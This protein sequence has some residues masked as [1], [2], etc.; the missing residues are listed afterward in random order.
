MEKISALDRVN[1]WA[2]RSVTLKLMSIGILVLILLIPTSMLTSL[3]FERETVR[4][5]AIEE[6]SSKW[7]S[8]QTIGG[9]VLTVPYQVLTKDNQGKTETEIRFAHFLPEHLQFTGTVLP[10]KRYRGIYVVVLYTAKIH[11]TGSFV[12]PDI[13]ALSIPE[14]NYL[15]KESSVSIGI[16]D[17]KGINDTIN[18][19]M[20]DTTY[21]FN[22]GLPSSE[23]LASG[24]SFKFNL[25]KKKE[26]HFEFDL[27]LNGS[28][29]LDFL[30]FGKVT[31]VTLQSPWSNPS[32]EGSFL[33]IKRDI[34][35][36][37]FT[38]SWKTL[39]LNRNYP[40]QGIGAFVKGEDCASFGVR[41]LLPIDEYQKTMR[42]VKYCIMFIIIT[43]LTFFFVEVLSK[44][45]IHPIQYLLVGFAI[46]IF[47]VLLLSISEHIKFDLAYLIGCICVLVLVSAYVKT[48]FRNNRLT[49]IFSGLL[50]LLYAFFYSLLQLEDYALLL[51][52]IGLFIIISVIMYL[53]RKVDW[54]G[55]SSDKKGD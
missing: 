31:T 13:Q 4:N 32:F 52:S 16:T 21:S 51:G 26:F 12:Y 35:S 7:G 1:N 3:V 19:R 42:S 49:Y 5:N 9:P 54:Y 47:Y 2:R 23:I 28:T 37:G 40:Q 14:G 45:Q 33:P 29:A 39:Q 36:N 55:V 53:T 41:L 46:C 6:V 15:F 22:P 34:N 38:A 17:M 10:E 44:K 48:I 24:A 25:P 18:F 50:A 11:V 43:F 30:P 27:N 8:A 20:N